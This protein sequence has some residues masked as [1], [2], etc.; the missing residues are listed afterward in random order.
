MKRR[1]EEEMFLLVSEVGCVPK[2]VMDQFGSVSH[3]LEAT[4]DISSDVFRREYPITPDE[5]FSP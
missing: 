3:W 2:D 4:Y 1:S 5:S